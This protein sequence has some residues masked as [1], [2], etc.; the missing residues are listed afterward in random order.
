VYR[1]PRLGCR[2]GTRLVERGSH[3]WTTLDLFGVAIGLHLLVNGLGLRGHHGERYHRYGRW[4]LVRTAVAGTVL[5]VLGHV[6]GAVLP[7]AVLP[8]AVLPEAVLAGFVAFLT[9]RSSST[10]S[11]RTPRTDGTTGSRRSRPA[12]SSTRVRP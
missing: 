5:G 2:A 1:P 4:A 7:G 3:G 8:G 9:D 6:P 10:P 12:P 11:A